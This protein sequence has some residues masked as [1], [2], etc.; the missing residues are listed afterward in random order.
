MKIYRYLA[1]ESPETSLPYVAATLGNL[2]LLHLRER[3]SREARKALE[4]ALKIYNSLAK[5]DAN[6]FVPL[7]EHMKILLKRLPN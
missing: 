6:Q 2:G 3:Q 5:E 1:E 7:A 4:E